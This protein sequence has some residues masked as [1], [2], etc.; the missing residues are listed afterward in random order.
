MA[1]ITIWTFHTKRVTVTLACTP[2][3]DPDL[4]WADAETL[5]KIERGD[6]VAVTF[7]VRVAVDGR[8][9]GEDYLG[10]SI[11]AD[12]RDF[13]RERGGYFSDMVANAIAE[14]RR[15]LAHPLPVRRIMR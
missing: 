7:R 11:Y 12:V 5:E 10:N 8:T 14:A 1:F 3:M 4:S 15:M 13:A 2:E 9:M 6:Y